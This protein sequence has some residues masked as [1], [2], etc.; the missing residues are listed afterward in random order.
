[1]P[2]QAPKD[3]KKS[4]ELSILT[5]VG[6]F[7]MGRLPDDG[8]DRDFGGRAPFPLDGADREGEDMAKLLPDDVAPPLPV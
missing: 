5:F 6:V 1:M 4:S 2:P 3:E 7:I 8:A